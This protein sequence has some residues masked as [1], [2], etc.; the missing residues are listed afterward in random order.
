MSALQ[1]LR[2]TRSIVRWMLLCFVL[3]IGV[4]VAAPLVQPQDMQLVCTASG[5]LKQVSTTSDGGTAEPSPAHTLQ[6]VMCLPAGAPPTVQ[7]LLPQPAA[8]AEAR[9]QPSQKPAVWRLADPT[10]ARDPPSFI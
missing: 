5:T 6:C 3:S 8:L 9:P 2:E 1:S 7:L 10:S 4:A